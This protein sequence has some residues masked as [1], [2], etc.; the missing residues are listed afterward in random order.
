MDYDK[1]STGKSVVALSSTNITSATDTDGEII[2]TQYYGSIVVGID[3]SDVTAGEISAVTFQEGD[4]AALADAADIS[5]SELLVYPTQFPVSA[6]GVIRIGCVSKKRYVR[7]KITT[8]TA[9][10]VDITASAIAE[11]NDGMNQPAEVTSSRLA[12]ADIN[13]PSDVGDTKVTS[14]KR[15]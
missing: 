1:F 6:A 12:T 9:T 13:A 3:V 14:P 15:T 11:L 10:T 4:D 7:L 2:D 5:A 8:T